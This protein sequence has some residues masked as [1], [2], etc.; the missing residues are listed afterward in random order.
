I[1]RWPADTNAEGELIARRATL[2]GGV[3]VV[4]LKTGQAWSFDGR[5][6]R[7][8]AS[9]SPEL[10]FYAGQDFSVAA[11]IKPGEREHGFWGGVDHRKAPSG[12]NRDCI[13][14]FVP[15]GIRPFVLPT[16]ALCTD[17]LAVF[18]FPFA[19]ANPPSP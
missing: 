18:G 19:R 1:A 15:S 2:T 5:T 16:V 11:W 8:V 17:A 3:S 4:S 9:D 14:F 13:R 10:R 6:G 7:V 12:G